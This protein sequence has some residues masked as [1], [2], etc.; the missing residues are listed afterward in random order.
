MSATATVIA[1]SS[2]ASSAAQASLAARKAECYAEM[3]AYKHEGATISDMRDY[4]SCVRLIHGTGEPLEPWVIITIKVVI[5]MILAGAAIGAWRG[6]KDDGIT[7]SLV[8]AAVGAMAGLLLPL[9]VIAAI[10]GVMFVV[11]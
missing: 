3:P 1:A 2:A 5:V 7:G 6:F 11:S 8:F 9:A 4:A 10:A